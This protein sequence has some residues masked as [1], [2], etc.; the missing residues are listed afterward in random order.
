MFER[1]FALGEQPGLVE[2]L[3]GLQVGKTAVQVRFGQ[4]GNGL[5]Q[6]QGHFI[7]N[8]RGSLE[9]ALLL[10]RQSVNTRRQHRLHGGRDLDGWQDLP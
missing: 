7:A 5:H 4:F 3:R 10:G 8:H 9:Q 2:E 1:E 6:R